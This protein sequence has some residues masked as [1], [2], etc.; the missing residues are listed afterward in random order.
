MRRRTLL[1]SLA[2]AAVAGSPAFAPR[3]A[4]AQ[5]GVQLPIPP[6]LEGATGRPI[7]LSVQVGETEFMP[8][9]ASR[10]AGYNGSYLGPTLRV[11]SGSDVP[12]VVRNR[13][14]EATTV[15][16]HGLL[17]PSEVDGGP[18]NDIAPGAAWSPVL[19]IRQL[20]A[21]AWYHA[22]PHMRTAPQVYGGLA[23]ML[24]VGDDEEQRLGLPSDYGVDDVP[25]LLH[26]R[27]FDRAQRMVYPRGM[28][29]VMHGA[30][31]DVLLANGAVSPW[32]PVPRGW[33]RLRLLNGANASNFDLRWSD[34]RAFTWIGTDG[35]LLREPVEVRR[36]LLAPAQRADVL[37][38]FGDGEPVDLLART[39]RQ[40]A[41]RVV[42]RGPR[43]PARTL[44]QRLAD[45]APPRTTDLHMREF[46]LDMGMGGMGGM[47]RGMQG[48][49]P[50][51]ITISGRAFDMHRVD[52]RVRLGETERWRIVT[53]P[54]MMMDMPH[55][56][57]VHG[58][59]F[60]VL[61]RDG[62]PAGP[63]DQGRRD[64]VLVD[65]SVDVAVRFT[66]PASRFPFMYHCHILEH[67]DHGMMGQFTVSA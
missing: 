54:S 41:L 10:T 55:P 24:I 57:H 13:L 51:G 61:A 7:E 19:P 43:L 4:A 29:T 5:P 60:E 52:H 38:D 30:M 27:L 62:R 40:P 53:R 2:C 58:V 33:V 67:E 3:M 46:S 14:D 20:A 34:G 32:T 45:W 6:L 1:R 42:P 66:Q 35:G 63:L 28:R 50:G 17:V 9:V 44:P 25:V 26:D 22:H 8:G 65:G 21:T 11:R 15:H 37:V 47:G 64:T 59:H 36:L 16:W 39:F 23:G 56:F 48:G 49:M 12:V 31:G 18:H